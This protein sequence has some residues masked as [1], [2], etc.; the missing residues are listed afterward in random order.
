VTLRRAVEAFAVAILCVGSASAAELPASGTIRFSVDY[1]G[2]ANLSSFAG[3]ASAG[4]FELSDFSF[5][6]EQTL[7]IG[8]QSSGAGAGKVDFDPFQINNLSNDAIPGFAISGLTQ[9]SN[10]SVVPIFGFAT[11][12]AAPAVP[13][14]ATPV[15]SPWQVGD[16]CFLTGVC[17]FSGVL[18]AYDAPE[19]VGTF[20]VTFVPSRV[21][22][23]ATGALALLGA[24]AAGATAR[25]AS[26][27]TR[28]RSTFARWK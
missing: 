6:I 22:E 26:P 15:L 28:A 7:N 16:S 21:P 3:S 18:V 14:G 25:R 19:Q 12:D 23:P 27:A 2:A 24:L 8:S 10:G 9:K 1:T 11:L 5:D 13:P 20:D 4:T 17:Q